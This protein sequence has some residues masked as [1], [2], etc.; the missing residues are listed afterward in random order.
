MNL[1]LLRQLAIVLVLALA[2]SSGGLGS[3]SAQAPTEFAAGEILVKFKPGTSAQAIADAHRQNGGRVKEVIPGIEVQVVSVPAGQE[4]ARVAAYARNPHVLFAEIN[5]LYYAIGTPN[6]PRVGEQWQY[7]NIGQTGGTDDADID[8]FEA[9]DVTIGSNTV[10]IAVLDSGIDQSHEDLKSKI[11]QNVNFTTSRTADDKYG[12]GTHVAGS[13]AAITNNSIGVAGTCPGCLLYNVKVLGDNGA[14]FTSWIAKGIVWA[15]D[16]GARVINMSLGGGASSTLESAVNYAWNKGVVLV[17]AAGNNNTSDPLYPAFYTNVIAVAATDH[18]D[19]KASFSNYGNW[20]DVAAPGV[21]ILSTA[22]DHKNR[23]WGSG[24]KYATSSGTS[25]ATPH[26]AGVAGLVWSR[27]LCTNNT[28]VRAQVE[29]TADP[30]SGTGSYW[31]YGRVN[32]CKAVGGTTC[33]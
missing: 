1:G 9:W 18:N 19:A 2:W 15:A 5:G 31:I 12:H 6:D 22:P 13:A 29:T 4:Q 30:I 21:S 24:V 3:T 11:A 20:V 16:H 8:A 17:A 10:T 32:A 14:G 7:N 26:V 27:G 33:N 23:I 28:C 25:M